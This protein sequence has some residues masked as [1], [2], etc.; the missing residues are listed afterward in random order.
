MMTYTVRI[1]TLNCTMLH[2]MT[3]LYHAITVLAYHYHFK[4]GLVYL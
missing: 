3:V 1:G 2:T 4:F